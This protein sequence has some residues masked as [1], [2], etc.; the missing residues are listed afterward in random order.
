MLEQS[1]WNRS[2]GA[3]LVMLRTLV[4]VFATSTLLFSIFIGWKTCWPKKSSGDKVETEPEY[5]DNVLPSL[6][7]NPDRA[8]EAG[9]QLPEN[10]APISEMNQGSG[11]EIEP[12]YAENIP[13]SPPRE[14]SKADES[15]IYEDAELT[16]IVG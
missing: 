9:P 7:K 14:Q 16:E 13:P 15:V 5:I 3:Q 6:T 1:R 11:A 12:E 8:T 4:G 2:G 10:V